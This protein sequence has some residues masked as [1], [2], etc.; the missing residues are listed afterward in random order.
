M[1]SE[2]S[3]HCTSQVVIAKLFEYPAKVSDRPLVRFQKG[4]PAGMWESTMEGSSTG[5]APHAKHV[6][7]LSFASNVRI[8]FTV[9]LGLFSPTIR[10]RNEQFLAH[11]SQRHLSLAHVATNGAFGHFHLL[12]VVPL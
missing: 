9:H 12:V 5:H 3:F 10:L 11:K 4:L 1:S 2:D 8:G 6:S 7:V